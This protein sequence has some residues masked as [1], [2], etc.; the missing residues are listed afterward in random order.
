[1]NVAEPVFLVGAERS[2]TTL[3][4]LMLDHHPDIAFH[5][6]FEFSLDLLG[7]NGE[8][9]PHSE[10]V[11]LLEMDRIFRLA[12]L[13]LHEGMDWPE[14]ILDF[15]EQFRT[16]S[17]KPR[18]GA[19]VHRRFTLLAQLLPGAKFIHLIRD[20]RDVAPSAVKMGWAGNAWAGAGRWVE[21]EEQWAH[22]AASLDPSAFLEI[23]YEDLIR[24]PERELERCCTLFGLPF[25]PAMLRYPEDSSYP[26]PD[27]TAVERWRVSPARQNSLVE[28]RVGALLSERGYEA[29]GAGP[30]PP[31]A[32]SR[33]FLVCGDRLGRFRFRVRHYGLSLVIG[34]A[35]ARR[36]C[37][38]TA[39]R[40]QLRMQALDDAHLR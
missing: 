27:P 7:P 38:R 20:P 17:G 11:R 13:N 10:R 6:E 14:Q 30:T 5:P 36:C 18:V 37:A 3:L 24:E 4:R 16:R 12:Q 21:A 31:N 15:L 29:S 35:L 1:M 28:A 34:H 39:Q 2:G 22:L 23:R 33:F 32:L 40:L 19:T 9:P 26:P 8:I 25:D